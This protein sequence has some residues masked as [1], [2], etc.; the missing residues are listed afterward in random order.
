MA[1]TDD[2]NSANSQFFIMFSPN[3]ALW[4]KYTVIGR[5]MSGMDA[6]DKIAVGEP[7]ANPTKIVSAR[8]GDAAVV[9]APAVPAPAVTPAA[10]PK[11]RRPGLRLKRFRAAP[12]R[13]LMRVDLFDFEL[14]TDR[15]ALRP[16]R[17]RDSARLLR[18]EGAEI[19]D[20]GVMDLPSLLRPGDVLLFND[21][22][23]IPAQLEGRAR[24][25]AN[26]R[27]AA[28]AR[29]AARA[30]GRSSAMRG[31]CMSATGSSSVEGVAASA[32]ERGEDGAFL[33]QFHGDEPVELLLARAGRMPLPPYI[34][35]K[36]PADE[37]DDD[38]YQTMFA[39]AEGRGGGADRGA[40]LHAAVAGG[41]RRARD[42]ARDAD[43]ARRR[44]DLPAGQVGHH[45]RAPDARRMGADRCG[46]G[47]AV[48]R[49]AGGGRAADRGRHDVAAA[50]RKRGRRG[51]RRS[52]RSRAT[53]RS[54]SRP[55]IA[56][57]RS[58]AWSPTSICRDRPCSCWSAR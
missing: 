48:E 49:G 25:G 42:R 30:G 46:D 52:S 13:R 34:A 16:A 12:M 5:V 38:D 9:Q 3:I 8:L 41:A 4:G 1:R 26:R 50:G 55:A 36:R 33:L 44:G 40:A 21:T 6:V 53:R 17:P 7:P 54:S 57:R 11:P 10:E 56:S 22:K 35:S 58:T 43:A 20:H 51:W 19:S 14:P 2:P 24:R 28:Q 32:V 37:A 27:D 47:R 23:V 29:R 45:R 31:G 15:I 39:K 18:V